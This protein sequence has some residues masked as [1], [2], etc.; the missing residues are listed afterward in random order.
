MINNVNRPPYHRYNTPTC[1]LARAF[2]EGIKNTTA[3]SS[4]RFSLSIYLT[5]TVLKGYSMYRVEERN[6]FY[7]QVVISHQVRAG[8]WCNQ[9]MSIQHWTRTPG[10]PNTPNS[11]CVSKFQRSFLASVWGTG[12]FSPVSVAGKSRVHCPPRHCRQEQRS[13][14]PGRILARVNGGSYITWRQPEVTPAHA[15]R[16]WVPRAEWL[17]H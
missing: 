6:L 8:I 13:R 4:V 2:P 10:T 3:I 5:C 1:H 16:K 15:W 11:H 9:N 14:A 17:R 7:D 12:R